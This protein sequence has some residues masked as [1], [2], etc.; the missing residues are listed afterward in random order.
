MPSCSP[1]GYA[2]GQKSQKKGD[3]DVGN[4]QG[5]HLVFKVGYDAGTRKH[6]K[7]GLFFFPTV[8]VR[9]YIK[10]DVKNSNILKKGYVFQPLKL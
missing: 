5:G 2:T 7:K 4:A 8:D 6:V 10:K 9:A 1:A 3:L